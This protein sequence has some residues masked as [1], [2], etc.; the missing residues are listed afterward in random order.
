M[1]NYGAISDYYAKLCKGEQ[2]AG[3]NVIKWYELVVKNLDA[4]AFIYDDKKANKCIRFIESFCRHHEGE[5]AP[6]KI[7]LELWQKAFL[8][9]IFGCVD[10]KGNRQFREVVLIMGRKNGKTL[11]ASAIATYCAFADGEYGGRI[12]MSAPKLQQANLCYDAFFQMVKN[13]DELNTLCKKRRTDIYIDN[14]NTSIS[15]L[16]FS[17]KKSD[18]LNISLCI[19]DEIAS[20]EGTAGLKFYE[21]LKS[22]FGARKQPLLLSI[23]TAGYSND[24]IYDELLKRSTAVINE[25]SSEKR[26]APF[27][28]QI[29]DVEHWDTMEEIAKA[30]PNVNISVTEDYLQEELN[31][32][33][34]SA[35]KRSEYLTKYCNIK[36]N[37][38]TAWLDA[39]KVHNACANAYNLEDF[40]EC[41]CVAGIDL[42]QTTDLTALSIVIEKDGRLYVFQSFFMP[43]ELLEANS[44]R[45][46]INYVQFAN[47]G[48]LTP[49][50]DSFVDYTDVYNYC[51]K[52][53]EEYKIYPLKIGYDRYSAQYLVQD[54]KHYGFHTDDVYQGENLTPCIQEVE[55]LINEGKILFN[56]NP[57]T[58]MH[59][60]DS[61][62]KVNAETRRRKLIK[63]EP[64]KHIDGTASLLDAFAVRQK[65]YD[66]IGQRLKNE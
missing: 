46:N 58:E 59:L 43:K 31:I 24:G 26:L 52:L 30:N 61:A 44:I 53:I 65:Y 5:L 25:T 10:H 18:G 66:E 50:G 35:S 3:A 12:Y 23:S 39:V 8:S 47:L 54:L 63:L 32:A 40:K 11:L 33:R 28:Y 49:S 36:Q 42:S 51:T 4:G 16:A 19:A 57:L 62:V 38:C 15:P 48:Y 22:S 17:V 21:V 37:S 45:D 60:L 14:S 34:A 55:G 29:D 7:K 13:D 56:N 9:V 6:N 20:W 64:R 27:I 2:I 41:Y 1:S